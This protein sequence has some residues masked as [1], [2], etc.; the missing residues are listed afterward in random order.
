M[1][2]LLAQWLML[3]PPELVQAHRM[4]GQIHCREGTFGRIASQKR[5]GRDGS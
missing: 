2:V 3:T 5:V 4:E 1:D